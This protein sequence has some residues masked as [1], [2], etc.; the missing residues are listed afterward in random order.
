[1]LNMTRHNG[2]TNV[3]NTLKLRCNCHCR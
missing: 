3:A 1:M 2:S